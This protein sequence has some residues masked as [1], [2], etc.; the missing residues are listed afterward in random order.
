MD[1]KPVI[2]KCIVCGDTYSGNIDIGICIHLNCVK[3]DDD[4]AL[5]IT[6]YRFYNSPKSF[7][8][9]LYMASKFLMRPI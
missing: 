2:S 4:D 1:Y 6:F 7:K 3:G 9:K 5:C 8:I